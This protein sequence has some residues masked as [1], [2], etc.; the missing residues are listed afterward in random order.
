MK[1]DSDINFETRLMNVFIVKLIVKRGVRMTEEGSIKSRMLQM[2][3]QSSAFRKI[4]SYFE[5]NWDKLLYIS[6]SEVAQNA[7]VSQGSVSRFCA[8]LGYQ[9]FAE[10]QKELRR[11]QYQEMT[12]VRRV[13][14]LRGVSNE[15]Q[16]LLEEERNATDKLPHILASEDFKAVVNALVN[17][18]RVI[19]VSARISATIVGILQYHLQKIRDNVS[20][21]TPGDALWDALEANGTEG[22]F[23]LAV[24][25]PRYP[26][27][28]LKK[29][30]AL[31]KAGY[32]T[33]LLSDSV[34]CPAVEFSEYH[35]E[36][37]MARK[38]IFDSYSAPVINSIKMDK[39]VRQNRLPGFFNNILSYIRRRR[40]EEKKRIIMDACNRTYMQCTDRMRRGTGNRFLFGR[41]W[42]HGGGF[43]GAWLC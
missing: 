27:A 11:Q 4:G 5:V 3:D 9:G 10:F 38:S 13:Q 26:V 24:A 41:Q 20:S 31:R 30:E 39:E 15:I 36:L 14:N 6:A 16:E 17:S 1:I 42:G 34:L 32:K 23:I 29:L 21:V 25:F 43:R 33:G 37:P 18:E 12:S 8:E 40:Y 28:L 7:G 19:L 22:C 2:A 35:L